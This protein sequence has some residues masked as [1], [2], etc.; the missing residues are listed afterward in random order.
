MLGRRAWQEGGEEAVR[1]AVDVDFWVEERLELEAAEAGE[2]QRRGGV[3]V[4]SGCEVNREVALAQV[5]GHE[6]LPVALALD[7]V[8]V[9][10]M[11]R[12]CCRRFERRPE[13]EHLGVTQ[14][15]L[16][17]AARGCRPRRSGGEQLAGACAG[18]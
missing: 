15:L 1:G 4:E 9:G 16:Q 10:R 14:L 5:A 2:E 3:C 6:R 7:E 13:L 12:S 11:V 8:L 18:G 17:D